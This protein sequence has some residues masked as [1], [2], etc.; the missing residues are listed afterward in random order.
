MIDKINDEAEEIGQFVDNFLARQIG[1][2]QSHGDIIF[3]NLSVIGAGVEFSSWWSSKSVPTLVLL[4]KLTGSICQGEML[5][6]VGQPGS[7][8]TNFLRALADMREEYFAIEGNASFISMGVQLPA[9]MGRHAGFFHQNDSH[10]D[11]TTVREALQLSARL[12][13]SEEV[14][15][16]NKTGHVYMVIKLLEIE[17]NADAIIG[18]PGAGL[19][20]ERRKRL[21]IGVELAAKPNIL[22]FLDEPLRF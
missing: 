15:L 16:E 5:M 8:C 2:S 4:H 19:D 9:S 11:S 6:V 21:S 3:E 7:G 14:P 17:D 10:L 1:A 18:V 22:L 13:R 12:R 20:L